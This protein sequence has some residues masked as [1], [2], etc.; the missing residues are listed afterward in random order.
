MPPTPPAPASSTDACAP[1][2]H[3]MC[4]RG[5]VQATL[6]F[7]RS[8]RVVLSALLREWDAFKASIAFRRVVGRRDGL[9]RRH[10]PSHSRLAQD[11]S[12]QPCCLFDRLPGLRAAGAVS[13]VPN[14]PLLLAQ[15]R[16]AF[17]TAAGPPAGAALSQSSVIEAL[18]CPPKPRP[19]RL[20][21]THLL[22]LLTLWVRTIVD[23]F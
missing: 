11:C 5:R 16:K 19:G 2:A 6:S 12:H 23:Q 8:W 4:S 14:N 1:T 7:P 9:V 21:A 20:Q 18:S 15:R 3:H 22:G 10:E 13:R 17:A